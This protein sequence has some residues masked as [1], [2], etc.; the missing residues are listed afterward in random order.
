[1]IT[2]KPSTLFYSVVFFVAFSIPTERA[3]SVTESAQLAQL[4]LAAQEQLTKLEDTIDRLE[5]GNKLIDDVS[6]KINNVYNDTFGV[7]VE[8][9]GL[10]DRAS[11]LH[12]RM[13]GMDR[14]KISDEDLGDDLYL[15]KSAVALADIEN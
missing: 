10:I 15:A 1:M 12:D 8:A 13:A 4:V 2:N 7:V 9:Y 3:N 6:R 14:G 11:S 5:E